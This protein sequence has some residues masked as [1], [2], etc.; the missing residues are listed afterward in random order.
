MATCELGLGRSYSTWVE[1]DDVE[2]CDDFVGKL[3]ERDAAE[4]LVVCLSGRGDKDVQ[5]VARY[6][7]FDMS[8]TEGR[9]A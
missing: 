2:V 5:T 6:L 4:A 1:S 8:D 3:S 9:S 7:G